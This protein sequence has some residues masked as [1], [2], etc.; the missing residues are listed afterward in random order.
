MA[1]TGRAQP[2]CWP[3]DARQDATMD[4][5]PALRVPTG[6][7][8]KVP[9]AGMVTVP[10]TFTT[11]GSKPVNCTSWLP[12][13][14]KGAV[15]RTVPSAAVV[16]FS[17]LGVRLKRKELTAVMVTVTGELFA[18]PSFTINCAIY[19]PGI[20]GTKVGLAMF[21]VVIRALLPGGLV[22]DHE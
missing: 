4:V 13:V 18:K 1:P 11:V 9:P 2:P 16:R 20:S 10:G 8:T 15:T 5:L 19:V 21:G 3:H 14:A 22:S 12:T 6:T 17:G 7:S